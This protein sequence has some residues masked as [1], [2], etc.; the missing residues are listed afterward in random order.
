MWETDSE[1]VLWRKDE[2]NFEK[3]VKRLEIVEKEAVEIYSSVEVGGSCLT[4]A[5][6][7]HLIRLR[8]VP[9]EVAALTFIVRQNEVV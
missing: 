7:Q 6:C 3:R 5:G 4:I 1:Q 2:K 9:G 8:F